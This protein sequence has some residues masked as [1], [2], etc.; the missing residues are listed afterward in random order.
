MILEIDDKLYETD[1]EGYLKDIEAWTR[2]VARTM[3]GRDGVTLTE[4][5][6]EVIH[7]LRDYY[8]EYG[9]AP[10]VRV[11]VRAVGERLGQDK[12]KSAYL[13]RLFPEGPA[14]QACRY[15]GL[16]KPTGCV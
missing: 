5:H 4:E 6:W 12:A 3:A 7:F 10:S 11:L 14:R 1:P 8:H 15:A 2:E 16:P 9:I 13:Y